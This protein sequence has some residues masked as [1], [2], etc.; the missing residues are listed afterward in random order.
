MLTFTDNARSRV[1]QFLDAQRDQGVSALRVAGNLRE[2]KLWL[3]KESDVHAGDRSFDAGGFTVY[4]DELS[5]TQLDGATVDFV[6]GVMQ[7]GFRVFV[8]S[9]TWDDPVLQRVQDVL[10]TQV[11][12]GVAGH[13][14]R[15]DLVRRDGDTVYIRMQGGCQGCGAAHVTL[16]QGV[17]VMIREAVPEIRTIADET[18][19]EAGENPFYARSEEADSPLA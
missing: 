12:P 11:N 4:I 9:P 14:G 10:D 13:G 1:T 18:D 6:D 17:E 2:P 16:R 3:I 8:P 5:A 15:I 7:S 19:H